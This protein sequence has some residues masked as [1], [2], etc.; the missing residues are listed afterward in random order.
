MLSEWRLK[1]RNIAI[2]HRLNNYIGSIWISTSY[3]IYS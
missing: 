2:Q 3:E 1:L